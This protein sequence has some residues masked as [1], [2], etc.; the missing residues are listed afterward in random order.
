MQKLDRDCKL[1]L[2]L[3][4]LLQ[5]Y[6]FFDQSRF[7]QLIKAV[8]EDK[9]HASRSNSARFVVIIK[10]IEIIHE[11]PKIKLYVA[12]IFLSELTFHLV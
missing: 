12:F 11:N 5:L 7:D 8:S 1:K 6:Q 3:S 9:A 4:L 2:S 10:M